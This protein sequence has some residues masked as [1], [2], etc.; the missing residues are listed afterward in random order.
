[1]SSC[2]LKATSKLCFQ[3]TITQ[4]EIENREKHFCSVLVGRLPVTHH[5]ETLFG[6]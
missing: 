3:K 2:Q 5:D 1:M 6:L 4:H